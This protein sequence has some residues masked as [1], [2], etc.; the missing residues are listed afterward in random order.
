MTEKNGIVGQMISCSQGRRA[1]RPR[2][3]R[4]FWCRS[5]L[6]SML[7]IVVLAV[8]Q[9]DVADEVTCGELRVEAQYGPYDYRG[10][11]KDRLLLVERNHFTPEVEQLKRGRAGAIGGGLES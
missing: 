8:P 7:L 3:T 5:C 11:R 9:P 2:V 10:A 6:Q 4:N 1:M